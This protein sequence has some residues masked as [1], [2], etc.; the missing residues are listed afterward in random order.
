MDPFQDIERSRL[1]V[2]GVE[3]GDEIVL[4]GFYGRLETGQIADNELDVLQSFLRC[5]GARQIRCVLRRQ[6]VFPGGRVGL[7]HPPPVTI[8]PSH[9]RTYRSLRPVF[10]AITS[11]VDGGS[12]L[13]VSK[14]PVMRIQE[15]CKLRPY[16]RGFPG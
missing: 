6:Q 10:S 5:L 14:S 16:N 3:R 12:P 13:M 9:S 8:G 11:A 15:D 2:H 1:V 7:D 4:L